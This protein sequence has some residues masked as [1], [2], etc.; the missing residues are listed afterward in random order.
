MFDLLTKI[1][2]KRLSLQIDQMQYEKFTMMSPEENVGPN[3][4]LKLF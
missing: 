1:N 2:K 4:A 3:E